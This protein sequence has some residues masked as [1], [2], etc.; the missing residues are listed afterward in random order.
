M[1]PLIPDFPFRI[2][3]RCRLAG[4]SD[5]ECENALNLEESKENIYIENL[6][7]K[8]N[9]EYPDYFPVLT[10]DESKMYFSSHMTF[11]SFMTIMSK[12][13][14]LATL[15]IREGHVMSI[16]KRQG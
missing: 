11:T 13:P 2:R 6:G 10:R 8:I 9:S 5:E 4:L 7:K 1:A 16:Q 14:L 15:I 12:H 3:E